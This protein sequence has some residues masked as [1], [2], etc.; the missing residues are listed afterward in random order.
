MVVAKIR[1]R[2]V[3][4]SSTTFARAAFVVAAIGNLIAVRGQAQITQLG[5]NLYAM[6][7]SGVKVGALVGPDGVFLVDSGRY[8]TNTDAI[9]AA[10]RSISDA[11]IRLVV[12]TSARIDHTGGNENF[13]KLGVTILGRAQV[14]ERLAHPVFSA[15]GM[16]GTGTPNPRLEAAL[17]VVTYNSPIT[18]HMDGEEI[19][20]IPVP[21]AYSDGDTVVHFVNA[22]VIMTGEIYQSVSYPNIDLANGG[23]L[24]GLLDGLSS[25]VA[26]AG[27]KTKIVP[28]HDTI[29]DRVAVVA[30]RNM[31]LVLRDR[32]AAMLKQGASEK[33]VV[34]ASL[35]ADYPSARLGPNR[36]MRQLYEEL[37]PTK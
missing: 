4:R 7:L 25:V 16:V 21:R 29:A 9:I 32:V 6:E 13:A 28:G 2:K 12:N 17:P 5:A 14:R 37:A 10:I 15:N 35:N 8:P 26:L 3:N 34:A 30:Q 1:R 23:T 27:P 22:D 31:I 19:E 36:F 11:P 18:L 20:V 24:Q 33:E